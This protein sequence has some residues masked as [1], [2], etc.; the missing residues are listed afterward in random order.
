M[1]AIDHIDLRMLRL[2]Q[3]VAQSGSFSDAGRQFDMPRAVVSRL[4][5]QLEGQLG[6]RLFQRTTRKVALTEEGAVMLQ[7]LGPAFDELRNALLKTH[8]KTDAVGGVVTLS[9]AHGFGR[10][11]V[12]PALA[13]F[14]ARYPDI[15]VEIRLAEGIDS[16]ID[17]GADLVIRQGGL[18]DS[19][20]VARRLGSIPV[21]LAV[22]KAVVDGP[23]AS[24]TIGEIEKLPAIGFRIPGS[25]NL[26]QWS[27]EKDAQYISVVPN[28][29]V[30]TT[31][32]IEA[33]ADLVRKGHGVAP[34]PRYLIEDAL[35]EQS[36]E[37][38]LNDYKA[39]SIPVHLC[40]GSKE[41]MPKRFRLLA[42]HL[43]ETIA[44]LLR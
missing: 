8:A 14:R 19:S 24:L 44:P 13:T 26:Y 25:G 3:N 12:L 22:P 1:N 30:L 35:A 33:V 17:G 23:A 10:H 4:I 21:V 31:D 16:L 6:V 20:I 34:V 36:I 2:F 40:F 29:H 18:P 38:A 37:T 11:Y 7:Q 28:H 32:S 9:V 27:F 5:A 39:P 42:D 15:A 43:F 41:L